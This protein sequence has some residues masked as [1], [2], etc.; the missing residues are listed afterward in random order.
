MIMTEFEAYKMYLAMR[1]HFQTEEYDVIKMRGRIRASRKSFFDTGKEPQ[2]RRLVKQYK[3][4]EI[5]DFFL[6][7]FVDGNR[8]GGVYDSEA[9]ECYRQWLA[10]R[11]SLRYRFE[12]DLHI[13]QSE[14]DEAGINTI[15]DALVSMEGQHPLIVRCHLRKT[16]QI[17][18]LVILNKLLAWTTTVD[19]QCKDTLIWPDLSRLIRKY[20]PFLRIKEDEYRTILGRFT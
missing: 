6:A 14:C 10:R 4:A 18:T 8:Y 2:F 1:N 13:L 5:C 19:H 7:N 9:T 11:E 20:N 15:A 3:D 16:L 17:E 12:Q